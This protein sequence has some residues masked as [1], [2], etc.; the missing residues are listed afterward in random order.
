MN[1]FLV[2]DEYWALAELVELF[3]VYEPE[4]CVYAFE[5]GEDAMLAAATIHP[6]LVLTDINMP[7]MDGLAL[8]ERLN[9]MDPNIRK[10]IVSVHDQF[11]YARKGMKFGVADFLVKP[12]KK[13]VLYKA[14]DHMLEQLQQARKHSAQWLQGA[15]AKMLLTP[16]RIQH[17]QLDRF[18]TEA[19]QIVLIRLDEGDF[20]SSWKETETSLEQL[21]ASLAGG[22]AAEVVGVELDCRQRVLIAMDQ[23]TCQAQADIHKSAAALLDQLKLSGHHVHIGV[24]KKPA[25]RS[26][27]EVFSPFSQ[28][29]K[30][31]RLFGMPSLVM[32]E[33][34]RSDADLTAV[35]ERVRV[36]ETHYRKGELA[37][38]KGVLQGLLK[39]LRHKEIT[40]RQLE[41]FM[42]DMLFSLRFN[43]Y[44]IRTGVNGVHGLYEDPSTLQHISSY[45]ELLICLHDKIIALYGEEQV[46]ETTPKELIAVLVNQIHHHYQ[47][48]I[49]LQQFAAEHHVSLGYLSRMFKAQTGLTF[50]EYV[51]EYR[52]RKAK[53]LLQGGVERLQEVS[54]LVGYEDPK[55]FSLLFKKQVGETPMMYA[56]KRMEP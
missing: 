38:G 22:A 46:S 47:R 56:K 15:L 11:E 54:R 27:F 39:E 10:I 35:W 12:V 51:T 4:H 19:C 24:A 3:K 52:I 29:L 32:A 18:Y 49:S 14:V 7:G 13:D 41:L 6:H 20:R 16:D 26:L 44:G 55:H 21:I 23:Q 50:S 45:D 33:E 48:A 40:K 1:I 36:L 43:K 42:G 53:E 34:K 8:V 9:Q 25:G 17:P 2:E 28:Q 37:K 31:N 5:N 30:D